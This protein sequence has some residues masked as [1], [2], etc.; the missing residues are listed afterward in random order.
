MHW[1][2][3]EEHFRICCRIQLKLIKIQQPRVSGNVQFLAANAVPRFGRWTTN[4][5]DYVNNRPVLTYSCTSTNI[6][7]IT[8]TS[9]SNRA[10]TTLIY[11]FPDIR[12]VFLKLINTTSIV[13]MINNYQLIKYYLFWFLKVQQMHRYTKAIASLDYG[14]RAPPSILHANAACIFTLKVLNNTGDDQR[15][16]IRTWSPPR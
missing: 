3:A 8:T 12:L 7:I 14:L 11:R 1:L 13:A 9:D 5:H 15:S 4:F 10:K 16:A 6:I 2:P